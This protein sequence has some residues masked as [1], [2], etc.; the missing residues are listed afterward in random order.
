MS[1][2]TIDQGLPGQP[3]EQKPQRPPRPAPQP[4]EA[5]GEVQR[6]PNRPRIGDSRPAPVQAGPVARSVVEWVLQRIVERRRA[7]TPSPSGWPR[8]WWL[9]LN[10]PPPR[11]QTARLARTRQR[12]SRPRPPIGPL[13]PTPSRLRRR[14]RERPGAEVS[15]DDAEETRRRVVAAATRS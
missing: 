14:G 3:P 11:R 7:K 9:W 1:D 15:D 13:G 12:R 5:A 2:E 4:S 8:A 6:E 10:A